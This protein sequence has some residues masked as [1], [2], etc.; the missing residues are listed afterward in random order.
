MGTLLALLAGLV[1]GIG[2]ILS[3]MANPAKVLGFLDLAG[4]WDPSLAFVM[5]GAIGVGVVAFALARR[6][7]RSWLGL[8]MQWP[9]LA[10]VTPRLLLGSAAFGTGWGLAG[11]CPGPALVA[12]GAG[13]AKAWGFVAAMLA[14]MALFEVA[15]AV[16]RRR[17]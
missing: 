1:F 8:P 14:G 15:E 6:R 10:A 13:Y 11:F 12:L 3:G 2:L 7:Q 5:A 4:M 16:T 17:R 9:A